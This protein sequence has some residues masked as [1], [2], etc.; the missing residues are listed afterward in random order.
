MRTTVTLNE[1]VSVMLKK[2]QK[3]EGLS[4]KEAVNRA[5]RQGLYRVEN[6]SVKEPYR[7]ET[8]D[9]GKSFMNLDNIG[10]VLAVAEGEDYR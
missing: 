9:M 2:L 10:E 5:L 4:F 7:I 8:F 6:A 3:E 1:N